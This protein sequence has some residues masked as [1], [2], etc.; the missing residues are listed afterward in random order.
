MSEQ[1][2][3]ESI[4]RIP[5]VNA[6]YCIP[7]SIAYAMAG[8][9]RETIRSLVGIPAGLLSSLVAFNQEYVTNI[10]EI[11]E[12][13]TDGDLDAL[14]DESNYL[15][16]FDYMDL[17]EQVDE[18]IELIPTKEKLYDHSQMSHA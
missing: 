1:R 16:A 2:A 9:Q 5:I 12:R 11:A 7:R 3:F 18:K 14:F 13:V 15:A 8:D 10:N 6:T 17:M 4:Q